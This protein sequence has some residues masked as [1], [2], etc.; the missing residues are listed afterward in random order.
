M[1][2]E[3]ILLVLYLVLFFTSGFA[4]H[5]QGKVTRMHED[6]AKYQDRIITKYQEF[7]RVYFHLQSEVI[8][9]L[10]LGK[11]LDEMTELMQ[12]EHER[13]MG[14][15][16]KKKKVSQKLDKEVERFIKVNSK[17]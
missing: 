14:K 10:Y 8:R 17:S 13:F 6:Y 2:S 16:G 9:Q 5:L 4:L 15:Y 7:F 3:Y 12:H 1:T 11:F